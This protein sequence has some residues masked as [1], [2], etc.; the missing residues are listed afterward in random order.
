MTER[1]EQV[2]V[3]F[4]ILKF[5]KMP[6]FYQSV[7]CL[8]KLNDDLIASSS[9]EEIMIWNYKNVELHMILSAHHSHVITL[10]KLDDNIIASGSINGSIDMWNY[11]TGKLQKSLRLGSETF[12]S[13]CTLLKLDDTTI[14]TGENNFKIHI[15]NFQTENL[16]TTL[17]GHQ[18]PV[19]SLI[20]LDENTFASGSKDGTIKIWNNKSYDIVRSLRLHGYNFNTLLKLDDDT[21]ACGSENDVIFIL[22][23]KTSEVLRY[24]TDVTSQTRKSKSDLT[25]S[26]NASEIQT[27]KET[28][29]RQ[30]SDVI[31]YCGEVD[32]IQSIIKFDGNTIAS[33]S[34]HGSIMIWNY[35]TGVLLQTLRG[36]YVIVNTLIKLDDNSIASGSDDTSIRIWIMKKN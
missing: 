26:S 7:T 17:E 20:Y 24:L 15:W 31:K 22:N 33:G 12:N 9:R 16:I 13:V 18:G 3:Y 25:T 36:H 29:K 1:V 28:L 21:L 27:K 14:A 19:Y 32:Y 30:T 34:K 4:K 5:W 23:Y 6:K 11:K 10:I 2:N 35:K 8:I